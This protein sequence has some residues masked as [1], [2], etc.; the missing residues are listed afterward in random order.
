MEENIYEEK[1][2]KLSR[3]VID[4]ITIRKNMNT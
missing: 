3:I 1:V 2:D 4:Y